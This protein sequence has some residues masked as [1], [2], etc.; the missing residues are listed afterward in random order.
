VC[1]YLFTDVLGRPIDSVFKG[2]AVDFFLKCLAVQYFLYCLT[3]EMGPMGCPETSISNYQNIH[4]IT[5]KGKNIII[6]HGYPYLSY[7]LLM[8]MEKR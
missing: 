5:Q 7:T 4:V 6:E 2:Q 1:L 8:L 3:L